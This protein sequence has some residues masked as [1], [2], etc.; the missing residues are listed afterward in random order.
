MG[1]H[2]SKRIIMAVFIL[3]IICF[4]SCGLKDKMSSSIINGFDNDNEEEEAKIDTVSF[5]DISFDLPDGYKLDDDISD[6]NNS[7]YKLFD[8]DNN[9][10]KM[11]YLMYQEGEEDNDILNEENA[12]TFCQDQTDDESI[13]DYNGCDIISI[14]DDLSALH[15]GFQ[16]D[17]A[18]QTYYNSA[19][20]FNDNNGNVYSVYAASSSEQESNEII[21]SLLD[22]FKYDF[23]VLQKYYKLKL[24]V[25][26]E[27][28]DISDQRSIDIFVDNENFGNVEQG[29]VFEKDIDLEEGSHLITFYESGDYDIYRSTEINMDNDK[30]FS[31]SVEYNED[32]L[33]IKDQSEEQINKESF[34]EDDEL[35][36]TEEEAEEQKADLENGINKCVRRKV[37]SAEK[38]AAKYGYSVRLLNMQG[39]M[40]TAKYDK[41]NDAEQK[42]YRIQEVGEIDHDEK[43]VD[44]TVENVV[45]LKKM[46]KSQFGDIKKEPLDDAF[47]Q[48]EEDGYTLIVNNRNGE[49]VD[50]KPG[51]KKS[52]YVFL[53]VSDIKYDKAKIVVKAD[54]KK[55]LAYLEAVKKAKAEAKAKRE[56]EEAARKKKERERKKKEKAESDWLDELVVVTRTGRCYHVEGCYTARNGYSIT[57]RQARAR[58]LQPCSKCLPDAYRPY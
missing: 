21:R 43:S 16:L 41:M 17:A 33:E 14:D 11:I 48:A 3:A 6:E 35:D 22:S 23:E 50:N 30:A 54:T 7:Y 10:Q 32:G 25:A 37:L 2:F 24:K 15:F 18:D 31:C 47:K 8:E 29:D 52:K 53:S 38:V 40:F 34:E 1:K 36:K 27:G 9:L 55:H 56:A 49:R 46:E 28:I 57:R 42:E 4:T 20:A 12:E 44:L 26:F 39:K 51:F 13:H 45:K 58:G 19:I 5:H